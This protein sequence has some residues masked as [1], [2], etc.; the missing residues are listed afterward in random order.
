MYTA[1]KSKGNSIRVTFSN[2]NVLPIFIRIRFYLINLPDKA[3]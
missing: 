3:K 1:K 2:D